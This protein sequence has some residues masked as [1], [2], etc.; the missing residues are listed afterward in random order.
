VRGNIPG[1]VIR[2]PAGWALYSPL[3]TPG[4]EVALVRFLEDAVR[5]A[6]SCKERDIYVGAGLSPKD[7]GLRDA[8]RRRRSPAWLV[9]MPISICGQTLTRRHASRH[10]R[11]ALSILPPSCR[12]TF[13][14]LTE[15]VF[16]L[17][18]LF[19]EPYVFENDKDRQRAANLAHR[20]STLIRDSGRLRGWSI[21]RLGDLAVC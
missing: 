8:A 6:E 9:S 20:W 16:M 18:W 15:T 3:E 2:R 21:E 10:D 5:Y 19:K 7:L 4:E 13:V 17:W 14:I 12:P 1:V 11:Q